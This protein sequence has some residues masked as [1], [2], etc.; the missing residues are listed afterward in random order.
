MFDVPFSPV[1]SFS[2]RRSLSWPD[3]DDDVRCLSR[4]L[5]RCF[6]ELLEWCF[7]DELELLWPLSLVDEDDDDLCLSLSLSA[8]FSL[9]LSLSCRELLLLC[10]FFRSLS[11]SRSERFLSWDE[12]EDF[13][14]V[15]PT[16]LAEVCL[17]LSC[18]RSRSRS[19]SLFDDLWELL[20]C[21]SLSRCLSLLLLPCDDECL[22]LIYQKQFCVMSQ[23]I[24]HFSTITQTHKWKWEKN[25]GK[26]YLLLLECVWLLFELLC[27]RLRS[28]SLSRCLSLLDD[29]WWWEPLLLLFDF[30]FTALLSALIVE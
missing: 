17:S 6:D 19:L 12:E 13:F 21:F 5:S 11:L 1:D 29:L 2:L 18:V 9:S 25:W 22:L 24:R 4:S 20:L 27:S 16:A 26:T 28:L 30:S 23:W 3:L 8:S 7:D 10:S 14:S 15:S